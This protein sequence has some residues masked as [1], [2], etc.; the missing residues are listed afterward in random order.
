MGKRL[1]LVGCPSKVSLWEIQL[2]GASN[3]LAAFIDIMEITVAVLFVF[4]LFQNQIIKSML[5]VKPEDRPEAS[6]LKMDLEE[7]ARILTMHKNMHH[8]NKTV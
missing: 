8:D 1:T 5:C 6:K 2:S 3:T 4:F 7:C